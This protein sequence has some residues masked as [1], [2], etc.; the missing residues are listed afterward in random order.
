MDIV[1]GNGF[2]YGYVGG[3]LRF[4]FSLALVA[5]HSKIGISLTQTVR[6]GILGA[7]FWWAA[8]TLSI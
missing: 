4:A 3:G 8:F 6:I 5:G 7:G 1:S 2:S